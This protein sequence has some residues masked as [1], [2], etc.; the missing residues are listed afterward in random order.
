MQ[1]LASM[2]RY[3]VEK[4]NCQGSTQ[5]HR[6]RPADRKHIERYICFVELLRG[7][8]CGGSPRGY[9]V[10]AALG[11]S[12]WSRASQFR[13]TTPSRIFS[14]VDGVNSW[15]TRCTSRQLYGHLFIFLVGIE[16]GF[17]QFKFAKLVACLLRDPLLYPLTRSQGISMALGFHKRHLVL[18][19]GGILC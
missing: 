8:K 12:Y 14:W 4:W 19:I 6:A 1:K 9:S 17:R 3:V 11:A 13:C 5:T 18:T 7:C 16:I 10:W 15:L 2:A